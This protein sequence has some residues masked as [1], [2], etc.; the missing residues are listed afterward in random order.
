MRAI[1]SNYPNYDPDKRPTNAFAPDPDLGRT[2]MSTDDRWQIV[3][4]TSAF[5]GYEGKVIYTMP[6][7]EA[8]TPVFKS[9]KTE[10]AKVKETPQSA[11]IVTEAENQSLG[12]ISDSLQ[13]GHFRLTGQYVPKPFYAEQLILSSL[14]G[15]LRS[16]GNWT[17]PK[18]VKTKPL[19]AAPNFEQIVN[20]LE[21]KP[22]TLLSMK[23]AEEEVS[24][25]DTSPTMTP[26]MLVTPTSSP[27][28]D[29]S[30]WVHVATQGRDHYV[31]IVYEGE[32]WPFRHRAALIK[33]TERKFKETAGIVGAYLM[34]RMY[35][36]VREPEKQFTER[37]SPFQMVR[38]TTTVTPDIADP[39]VINS[40]TRSFWV[41]VTTTA[42]PREMFQ[43]H[44]VGKDWSGNLIDFT[45]PEMFVSISDLPDVAPT[46]T[47]LIVE[48][49]NAQDKIKTRGAKLF[50]NKV[51]FAE[52][53]SDPA[54]KNDNTQLVTETLNFVVDQSGNPAKML[55]ATVK[56]PQVQ[57][58]LGKDT[59]TT[60][61][62][63]KDYVA[64]GFD[65]VNGVFAQIVSENLTQNFPLNDPIQGLQTETFGLG[66]SSDKAGGFATPNMNLSTLTRK[67]GPIAGNA[68]DAL[69]D[70]FDPN[71]VLFGSH[72][73]TVWRFR[74]S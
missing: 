7:C 30:E 45:I 52:Q 31:R 53:D 2:A 16:R 10:T 27:Q 25:G 51:T 69:T 54:N 61:A 36:V 64:A 41:E 3:I 57:D 42:S 19:E 44:A 55:F 72:R 26:M 11:L 5:H 74:S 4:L 18:R 50:G 58:L 14:G 48:A 40:T 37:A 49:Y 73:T 39:N 22:S 12:V 43:F 13:A 65:D 59:S 9:A 71:V 8:A 67:L 46:K 56:I 24:G 15:W 33:V 70:N 28:L 35:I 68:V 20:V 47:K 21:K 17:P 1:W 34:Q 63:Y 23:E 29:L 6:Q 66:F 38:L 32:L 60:I 62:Y